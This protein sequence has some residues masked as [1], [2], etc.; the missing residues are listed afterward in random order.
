VTARKPILM[1][2]TDGTVLEVF[3]WLSQEAIDAA[4]ANPRVQEMW[5]EFSAVCEYIPVSQVP[6]AAE[7][8]SG[9]RPIDFGE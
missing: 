9:F 7:P 6:E 3:E 2:A 8:F 1:E 5:A 4:H